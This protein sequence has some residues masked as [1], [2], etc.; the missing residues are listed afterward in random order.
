LADPLVRSAPTAFPYGPSGASG[1]NITSLATTQIRGLGTISNSPVTSPVSD[2]V[3]GP[4]KITTGTTPTVGGTI[5][6]HLVVSVDGTIF[7]G[8][9]NP[10]VAAD[11]S[12][13]WVAAIAADPNLTATQ[14]LTVTATSNVAYYFREFS[15]VGILGYVPD[16]WSL[17]VYNKTGVAL[18]AT[19]GNHSAS[20]RAE[21]YV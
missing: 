19:A 14:I 5:E 8:G 6:L 16:Y 7:T 13:A 12:T 20:Y 9:V 2:W 1:D 11:Q 3:V 17:L 10:A 21:T 15:I 18:N 4:I